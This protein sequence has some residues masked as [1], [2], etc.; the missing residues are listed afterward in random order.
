M[1]LFLPKALRNGW[2]NAF[3]TARTS[4]NGGRPFL[5]LAAKRGSELLSLARVRLA[6]VPRSQPARASVT[7]RGI[8]SFGLGRSRTAGAEIAD[9]QAP[10]HWQ[11]RL[12]LPPPPGG[13][14][15]R[16]QADSRMSACACQQLCV[17]PR[18]ACR[19][20]RH[21]SRAWPRAGS[22]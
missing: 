20:Q 18:A 10:R 14:T 4:K 12:G 11:S 13:L 6:P 8:F 3:G 15:L 1:C 19:W 21:S 16:N 22:P 2:K 5:L 9:A 17:M 7:S